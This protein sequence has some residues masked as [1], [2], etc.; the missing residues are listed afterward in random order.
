M[1]IEKREF[2]QQAHKYSEGIDV[3]GWYAS[4][5]LDG[6]RAWWD[7][8]ISRGILCEYVPYSSRVIVKSGK[9]KPHLKLPAT[10]LWSRYGNPIYAPEYFLNQLPSCMLDGELWLGRGNFQKTSSVVKKKTPGLGWKGIEYK[11][12]G[13]PSPDAMFRTGH[14]REGDNINLILKGEKIREWLSSDP[15]PNF[16]I[17]D[18]H[19]VTGDLTHELKFIDDALSTLPDGP[20]SLHKQVKLC[21]DSVVAARNLDE[22]MEKAL[23][24][25]AEGVVVRDPLQPW[26]LKRVHHVLKVKP[27]L[28]DEATVVGF[29]T[30]EETDK[31]SKLL[32]K[33]G[34]LIM[35]WKG[36]RFK[37]AGLTDEEREFYSSTMTQWAEENPRTECPPDFWGAHFHVGETV[38]FKYMELTD[39]GIPRSPR[40]YRKRDEV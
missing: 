3:A 36:K 40:Y 37:M 11:V 31:G 14:I 39:D 2:L 4:E 10:G 17:A 32:G 26:I 5:K 22:M 27:C 6:I 25:G 19:A 20:A 28:D 34:S 33:I 1:Q 38:T 35:E 18:W 12:F 21:D 8:G 9:P 16:A 15:N 29:L 30:G 7:G 24:Y 23:S 13:S